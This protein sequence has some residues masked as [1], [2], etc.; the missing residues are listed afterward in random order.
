MFEINPTALAEKNKWNPVWVALLSLPVIFI[1][2]QGFGTALVLALQQI[3]SISTVSSLRLGQVLGQYL[4]LLIPVFIF[5]TFHTKKAGSYTFLTN[6]KLGIGFLLIP[7]SIIV[8]QPALQYLSSLERLIQWPQELITYRD[9]MENMTR[10]MID[11]T[12]AGEFFYIVFIVAITPA[13]C[14]EFYF[15]GYILRNFSRK[16]SP[17]LSVLLSGI[18]FGLFHFNPFQL[19]GLM[20]MGIYFSFLAW[21]YQSLWASMTAHFINNFL[22]VL[23]YYISK[24]NTFGVKLDDPNLEIPLSL[25]LSSTVLF[26]II[27]WLI[28]RSTSIAK[29]VES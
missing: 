3:F 17:V 15:R 6:S 5:T 1:L 26:A 12:S 10:L 7:L 9:Q 23:T 14:E 4:F 13:F 2:Y 28:I 16:L 19:S 8:L 11:S 18:I 29:T 20:I 24:E 21:N 22:V 27:V 25:F